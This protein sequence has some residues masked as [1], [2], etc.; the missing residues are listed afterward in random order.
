MEDFGAKGVI[1]GAFGVHYFTFEDP[2]CS[3]DWLPSL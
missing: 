2:V 1:N 3:S